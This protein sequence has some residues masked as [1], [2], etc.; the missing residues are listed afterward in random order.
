MT[1]GLVKER[2]DSGTGK[3]QRL[4]CLPIMKKLN[5]HVRGTDWRAIFKARPDLNPPGYDKLFQLI[6]KEKTNGKDL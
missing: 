5:E 6:Q 4:N 1:K 2:S 3:D